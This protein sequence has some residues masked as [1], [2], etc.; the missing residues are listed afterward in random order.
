M[1][2][3][4]YE[5]AV[6]AKDGTVVDGTATDV[7]EAEE[8]KPAASELVVRP[9][10]PEDVFRAMDALDEAQ[11]LEALEGRPSEVM[12][13]SFESGGKR[14]TGLSYTGVAEVVRTMNANGVTAIE[15]AA[16]TP[17]IIEEVQEEDEH[18]QVVTYVQATVFARDTRN[19]GGLWGTARQPKFQVFKDKSKKPRLDPFARAK[20]LS[21]AQRNAMLPM[22]PVAYRETLIALHMNNRDRVRELRLGM[23]DPTAELPPPLTDERAVALKQQ[24]RDVYSRIRK[25]DPLALPPGRFNVKLSRSEHEHERMEELLAELES[26]LAHMKEAS[27]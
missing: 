27:S 1:P 21:K 18:G 6:V 23:G 17:P 7:D 26:M 4:P 8:S 16:D 25:Q 13:Y 3:N 12:V 5:E 22:T 15:V 14:Q 10:V 20:A 11:I 24:I 2:R 19:G 9:D